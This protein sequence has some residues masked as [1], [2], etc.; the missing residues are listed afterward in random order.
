M[1]TPSSQPS[2]SRSARTRER[3][4][5]VSLEL[6]NHQGEAN[7]ITGHSADELN[8]SPLLSRDNKLK[9]HFN[10]IGHK[11]DAVIALCH[12]L[13]DVPESGGHTGIMGSSLNTVRLTIRGETI[14]TRRPFDKLMA[15]GATSTNRTV[16]VQV[17]QCGDGAARSHQNRV[18]EGANG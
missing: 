3:I 16:L 6:F 18:K 5:K 7:V 13:L 2:P 1:P 11:R 10:I 17:L 15:N 12:A 4:L 14:E 9:S 8:I